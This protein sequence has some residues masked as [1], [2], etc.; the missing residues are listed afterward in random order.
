MFI[1][2]WVICV[3][4]L[5]QLA[6]KPMKTL[7]KVV[8]GLAVMFIV[9]IGIVYW[10]TAG[11]A[12]TANAFF[13][14][15][16][17]Q[18]LAEARGYL[19]EDFKASTDA[20]ALNEFLT[21]SSILH[22]KEASWSNRETSGGRGELNGTIRTETGGVVPLKVMFIKEN[23]AWKIYGI[24]KPTAGLQSEVSSPT[25][26][27][28]TDQVV[29]VK[30]SMHEFALSVNSKSMQHFRSTVSQTW[31]RQVTT[32]QLDQ[33]FGKAYGIGVDLTVLDKIE[34][35]LD[36]QVALGKNGELV[37]RGY[38]A[39][40]PDQVSFEQ[41]YVYEGIGWKLLGFG[42]NIKKPEQAAPGVAPH[43]GAT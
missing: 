21:Q 11:M 27:S 20:T 33:V 34:P 38:Y 9:A 1:G 25:V 35:V 42:F 6:K 28:K 10:L 14:A 30:R 7:L 8:V 39:T 5:N 37:L 15:I 31:Q 43:P 40:R 23:G 18:D 3:E 24:Q 4:D 36:G 41:S 19:S 12:D 29:L 13:Q 26:P 16:K 17:K 2:A 22:F 32:E